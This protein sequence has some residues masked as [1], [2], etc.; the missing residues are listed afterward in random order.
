[1]YQGVTPGDKPKKPPQA[2]GVATNEVRRSNNPPASSPPVQ[3]A[4]APA[5]PLSDK[6]KAVMIGGD[7]PPP[8]RKWVSF[9]EIQNR[10]YSFR[11][12]AVPKLFRQALRSQRLTLP[13]PTKP[14]QVNKTDDP[15]YCP[16]HRM[17]GTK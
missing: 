1:M 2:R 17:V 15:L 12:D 5:Q 8:K 11:Q 3:S 13:T 14:E 16:Y 6:E 4:S 9:E 7:E 10:V